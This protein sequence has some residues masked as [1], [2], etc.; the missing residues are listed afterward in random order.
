WSQSKRILRK[1][2]GIDRKSFLLFLKECEFRFNFGTPKE[3]LKTLRKW[4]EI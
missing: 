1:Y 2:N 4:C 3:Q